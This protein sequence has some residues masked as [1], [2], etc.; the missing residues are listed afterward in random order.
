[1]TSRPGEMIVIVAP[2]RFALAV[3]NTLATTASEKCPDTM[4]AQ[5]QVIVDVSTSRHKR[6]RAY[7]IV[8]FANSQSLLRVSQQ[9]LVFGCVRFFLSSSFGFVGRAPPSVYVVCCAF[10]IFFCSLTTACGK[11]ILPKR[12]T[13]PS[14]KTVGGNLNLNEKRKGRCHKRHACTSSFA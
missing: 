13:R 4:Q 6:E 10:C 14:G 3:E 11:K 12:M 9:P 2:R 8:F 7:A 5:P 1:M